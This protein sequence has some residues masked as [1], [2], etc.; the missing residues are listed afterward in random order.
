[1]SGPAEFERVLDE[2]SVVE[3]LERELR[4]M[5]SDYQRTLQAEP[6]R[7]SPVNGTIVVSSCALSASEPCFVLSLFSTTL[8]TCCA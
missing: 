7:S 2:D 5:E 3:Q 8:H 1:M 6:V 4:L